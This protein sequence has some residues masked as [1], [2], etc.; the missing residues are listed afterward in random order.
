MRNGQKG[1]WRP[2]GAGLPLAPV[3]DLRL[4]EPSGTLFAG[5]FGRSVWKVG[6]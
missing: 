1:G 5:T 3:L 4:H 6:V 2:V